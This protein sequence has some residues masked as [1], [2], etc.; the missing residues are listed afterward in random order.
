MFFGFCWWGWLMVDVYFYF[1]YFVLIC[2]N[3]IFGV[4]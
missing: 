2:L 1:D 3:Q 4:C